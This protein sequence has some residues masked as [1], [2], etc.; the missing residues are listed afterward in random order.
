[1]LAVA[2]L[3]VFDAIVVMKAFTPVAAPMLVTTA[4]FP[5]DTMAI[6]PDPVVE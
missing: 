5:P 4:A 2:A 3:A 6:V 1:L